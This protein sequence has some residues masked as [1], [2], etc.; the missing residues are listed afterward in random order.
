V[1]PLFLRPIKLT[2]LRYNTSPCNCLYTSLRDFHL[3]GNTI[4]WGV[5]IPMSLEYLVHGSCAVHPL[6]LGEFLGSILLDCLVHDSH[7]IHPLLFGEFL[8][9][10]LLE[11]LVYN[12]RAIRPLLLGKCLVQCCWIALCAICT[13]FVLYCFWGI[14]APTLF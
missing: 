7:A 2:F 5:F 6:L 11:S 10:I 14:P 12:S 13:L 1:K 4:T 9:P 3:G 8:G